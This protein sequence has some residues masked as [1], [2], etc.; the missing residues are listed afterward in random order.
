MGVVNAV[1]DDVIEAMDCPRCEVEAGERC[2]DGRDDHPVAVH[3]ER[4][5]D[6]IDRVGGMEKF[7]A[8]VAATGPAREERKRR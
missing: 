2:V 1:F 8:R 7:R 3:V 6:Y 5:A 4:F